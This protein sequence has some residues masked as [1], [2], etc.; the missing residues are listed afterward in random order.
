MATSTETEEYVLLK[1]LV[2][3]ETNKVVFAEAGKDFV[4]ILCS[5]LTLPLGTI[6]KLSQKDSNMGPV[7]INCLN[8]LYQSVSDL[9]ECL[10]SETNNELLLYPRNSSED[11]CSTLKINI[12]DLEYTEYFM[13][14][15]KY[16][17]SD[18]NDYGYSFASYYLS[19]SRHHKAAC[20][21]KSYNRSVFLKP[22]NKGFVNSVATF[23]I[24]D[25]LV[26]MPNSMVHNSFSLLQNSGMIATSAKEMTVHVTEEKVLDLLKCAM[27][28]KSP[29]T[30]VFLGKKPSIQSFWFY[31]CDLENSD[32][33]QFTLQLVIRKSDRKV[34]FAYGEH[35]FADLLLSFLTFP[36]GGVASR[37]GR[38]DSIGSIG[39]LYRSIVE[40]DEN[41]Y[42]MSKEAKN[43]VVDP[44]LDKETE[45]KS[46]TEILQKDKSSDYYF[47]YYQGESYKQ[48]IINDQFF[49]SN[50]YRSDNKK[51]ITMKLV[52]AR[53][54]SASKDQGYVKGPRTYLVTDDLVIGPSSPISGQ[55]VINRLQIPPDDLKEKVVMIGIKECVN[56]LKAAL[57]S[58]SA[59][60]N[61][62]SHLLT[63]AK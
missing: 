48:S 55:L 22:Y 28:S 18:S 32:N 37:L 5:F 16:C 25:D 50:E 54:G 15:N 58:T 44:H 11:Y 31:C 17:G 12:D 62:L 7:T 56:I 49:I 34:L 29:L 1:L 13:C 10:C 19:T 41:K 45:F 27:V 52:N 23:V 57:I 4:D 51:C 3:E 2:N 63:E 26:I 42:F 38:Y 53:K 36:L 6:A 33:I 40:L 35:D 9:D 14:D 46:N 30:D 60:T 47:C 43:R 24:T 61:G 39:R 20:C 8:T 21:G 59:L